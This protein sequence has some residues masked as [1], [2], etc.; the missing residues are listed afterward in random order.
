LV[1]A[2]SLIV[3]TRL[4]QYCIAPEAL[5]SAHFHVLGTFFSIAFSGAGAYTR[6]AILGTIKI[7]L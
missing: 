3:F 5:L 6:R 1:T 7:D 4:L 2:F